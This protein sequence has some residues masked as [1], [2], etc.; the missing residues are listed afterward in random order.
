MFAKALTRALNL[1]IQTNVT[2][3]V[4]VNHLEF[5]MYNEVIDTL[6]KKYNLLNSNKLI[7]LSQLKSSDG[8]S[9]IFAELSALHR[10]A[11]DHDQRI[12]VV[13]PDHDVYSY[14]ENATADSLI[15]LQKSLQKIDISNFF[16]IVISSNPDIENELKWVQTTQSTDINPIGYFL[17][18]NV[19]FNKIE[20]TRDT[21]CVNMWNHLYVSTQ[22]EILPCCIANDQMPLGNLVD[23]SVDG[24][25]NGKIANQLRLDMLAGKLVVQCKNC[26]L[27][28]DSVGHSRRIGD[29]EHN[30]EIIPALK[31]LTNSDGSLASFKPQTLDIRLNN[32]CNLKCRTCSGVSSSMLAQEEKKLFNNVVNFEKTPTTPI[33]EKIFKS[34]I[35]YFDYA[36]TVYFA[37]GEPLITKEHYDILDHLIKINKTNMPLVYN[38]NFTNLTYKNKNVIDHWKNFKTV[39]V[40]A[41]LDGHGKVFE[42]V[43]HGAKWPDI[44]KNLFD[45]KEHPHIQID[46]TSTVSLVS[47][48]SIIELQRMWHDT[49]KL[50][51]NNFKI[52]LMQGSDYLS[53]QSLLSDHKKHVSVKIDNHHTWLI[54]NNA[55]DLAE[56]WKL[57]Q[58]YMWLADKSY[59]NKEFAHVNRAR[60]IARNECFELI[61]PQ[62]SD[63][64]SPYY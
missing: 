40:G 36:N 39:K 64:F 57:I 29:N 50:D 47:I 7:D 49:G 5:N 8:E 16:V 56:K 54:D 11:F 19:V 55:L 38:T 3:A 6:S 20:P 15:F 17:L 26:Y 32:I 58:K 14:S 22:L 62:F 41:S 34:I 59:V 61:Y 60:D 13:Q 37:G 21:F 1:T 28:E 12:I 4:A 46:I 27:Q 44:E 51:I 33:R 43:R 23:H 18:N 63:L 30:K 48:E 53:L 25:I 24:I 52:N 42:Y 2:V 10:P 45:L 9:K 35:N 31:S